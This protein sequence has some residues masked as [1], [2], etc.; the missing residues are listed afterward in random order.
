MKQ[1]MVIIVLSLIIA[2]C[3]VQS[4][5]AHSGGDGGGRDS[6]KDSGG[7][8]GDGMIELESTSSD[9]TDP[10]SGFTPATQESADSEITT[11][12]ET[13]PGK[14]EEVAELVEEVNLLEEAA[15]EEG[16]AEEG[17][18]AE[19]GADAEEEGIAEDGEVAEEG[20]TAEEG[21]AAEEGETAEE[22][23]TVEEGEA[24]AEEE[25][26]EEGET[27]EEEGTAEE[28]EAVAE[29]G[30]AE[31]EGESVEE[32]ES[33]EEGETAEEETTEEGGVEDDSEDSATGTTSDEKDTDESTS[34]EDQG[35]EKTE[36][37]ILVDDID[38]HGS[39]DE[40]KTTEQPD[41]DQELIGTQGTL[42]GTK[43][44]TLDKITD[45]EINED[46]SV[47]TWAIYSN[48]TWVLTTVHPDGTH[49]VTVMLDSGT[50]IRPGREYIHT[51]GSLNPALDAIITALEV[52]AAAGTVA[53]WALTVTP[54]G[55]LAGAGVKSATAVWGAT[56]GVQAL[57]AGADAYGQNI[58][59]GASQGEAI[60]E[61]TKQATVNAVV[62][63]NIGKYL[64]DPYEEAI[65]SVVGDTGKKITE[66]AV[67]NAGNYAAH[68]TTENITGYGPGYTPL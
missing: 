32:G 4:L 27:A 2:V 45:P 18:T 15:E 55:A 11:S 38:P 53:G 7:G 1:S 58:D 21:E 63:T 37:A 17:E 33:A 56:I 61:G 60:Y 67:K 62:V 8:G 19:E 30:T 51:G 23:G 50:I 25:T 26:A 35:D 47:S 48:D 34:A 5:F 22:E 29:E 64:G 36:V 20:E 46:G 10:P 6:G 13:D 57:R 43:S 41:P 66:F 44:A 24:V 59:E 31:E 52:T 42:P 3:P 65:G 9:A 40:S 54:A 49:E 14:E 12:S 68:R 28:G 16:T 39:A